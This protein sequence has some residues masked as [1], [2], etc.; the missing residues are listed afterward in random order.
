MNLEVERDVYGADVDSCEVKGGGCGPEGDRREIGDGRVPSRVALSGHIVYTNVNHSK[1]VHPTQYSQAFR[2]HSKGCSA[3]A[4]HP[5]C[6]EQPLP[7][8]H[9]AHVD[10]C[11]QRAFNL[12]KDAFKI[13]MKA[14]HNLMSV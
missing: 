1:L 13:R 10:V 7:L 8:E 2:R 11:T 3:L 6:Q 12:R 9:I 5:V 14:L 4:R